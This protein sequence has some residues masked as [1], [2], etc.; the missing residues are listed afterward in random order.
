ML[1]SEDTRD[2]AAYV[3]IVALHG[4]GVMYGIGPPVAHIMNA[5]CSMQDVLRGRLGRSYSKDS[6]SPA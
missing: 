2:E 3:R 5:A 1:F 6:H 4:T